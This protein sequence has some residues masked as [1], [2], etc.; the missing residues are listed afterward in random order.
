MLNATEPWDALLASPMVSVVLA[1]SL[2]RTLGPAT[3]RGVSSA[4]VYESGIVVTPAAKIVSG[5]VAY[6][7]NEIAMIR[8][9]AAIFS[10]TEECA[11]R[12]G[13][14]GDIADKTT[15]RS[16]PRSTEKHPEIW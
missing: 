4:V 6:Q 9:A 7:S 16:V 15:P 12:R 3:C 14:Y 11:R 8:K 10:G 2:A 5:P 1:V 13:V